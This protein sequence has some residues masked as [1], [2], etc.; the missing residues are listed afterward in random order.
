MRFI[1][2]PIWE[3]QSRLH[4]AKHTGVPSWTLTL[5]VHANIA[6]PPPDRA[7]LTAVTH[8]VLQ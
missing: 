2:T 6:S 1:R 5:D 4:G 7:I 3:P 8:G